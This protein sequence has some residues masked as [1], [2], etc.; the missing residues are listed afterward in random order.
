MN[1]ADNLIER[2]AELGPWIYQFEIDGQTYGGGISAVGDERVERFFDFAP[3]P[4]SILEFGALQGAQS[5]ILAQHPGVERVVALEGREANL[6]KARFVRGLLQLRNVEFVQANLEAADLTAFGKFDAIFCCGLLYHL[7]EPWLL[8][9]QFSAIAPAVFIWTHYAAEHE[10]Q[11]LPNGIRGKI[12]HEAGPD[13]PWSGLS[14]PATWLP[15]QSILSA[16][17]D[18]GYTDTH[19][20]HD[21]PT[22]LNGPAATIGARRRKV[23]YLSATAKR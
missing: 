5:F 9:K 7:P 1:P 10:V 6:R 8:L 22:H 17:R 16:L 21:D 15:L 13:D 11:D 2:F 19:V 4:Q 23:D 18:G 20:I 3:N 14:P 12:H